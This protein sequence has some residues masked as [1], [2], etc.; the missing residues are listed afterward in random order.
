MCYPS[1]RSR[2]ENRADRGLTPRPITRAVGPGGV[3]DA[4]IT[5]YITIG[6][7]WH[8][9]CERLLASK[10]EPNQGQYQ[11]QRFPTHDAP[12]AWMTTHEVEA[13]MRAAGFRETR[14]ASLRLEFAWPSA[15]DYVRFWFEGGHPGLRKEMRGW[16]GTR[17]KSVPKS[18]RSSG[19]STAAGP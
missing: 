3:A 4:S 1:P 15:E 18:S 12:P 5:R 19:R 9:A 10:P 8:R 14:S 13:G 2:K 11:Y 6:E 7:P 17:T 16:G